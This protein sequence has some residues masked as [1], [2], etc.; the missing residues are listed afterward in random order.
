[1]GMSMTAVHE[2][3]DRDHRL[4]VALLTKTRY[5]ALPPTWGASKQQR[6]Q[7]TT[8]VDGSNDADEAKSVVEVMSSCLFLCNVEVTVCA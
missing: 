2:R 5:G 8:S 6:R 1:M 3:T 7:R 4:A